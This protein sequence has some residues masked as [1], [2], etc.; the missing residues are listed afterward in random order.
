MIDDPV[1]LLR[2]HSSTQGLSEEEIKQIADHAIVVRCREGEFVHRAG[3]TVTSISLVVQGRFRLTAV[4]PDGKEQLIRYLRA[5]DQ[6]GLLALLMNEDVPLSCVAAENSAILRISRDSAEVLAREIPLLRQNLLR[7]LGLR[8]KETVLADQTSTQPRMITFLH[9]SDK[10]RCVVHQLIRCLTGLAEKISLFSDH[11]EHYRSVNCPIESLV[12]GEGEYV[13][14]EDIRRT[15]GGWSDRDRILFDVDAQLE[16]DQAS[17][18][19]ELSDEAIWLVS[20]QD[21]D[22]VVGT[23]QRLAVDSPGWK[24]KTYVVWVL[25]EGEQV[26]PFVACQRCDGPQPECDWHTRG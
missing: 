9:A 16:L 12:D 21:Y 23:L 15:A 25:E 4:T 20:S 7:S 14:E 11:P 10:S 19:I 17:R 24:E 1:Q 18:L 6:F 3:D 22:M 13:T 2:M 26:A 8:L 5:G